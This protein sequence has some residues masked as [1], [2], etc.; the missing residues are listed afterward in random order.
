MQNIHIYTQVSPS[1]QWLHFM[2][3]HMDCVLMLQMPNCP[4]KNDQLR[5]TLDKR[6][7]SD[8]LPFIT[9]PGLVLMLP[10]QGHSC[11]PGIGI[12]LPVPEPLNSSQMLDSTILEL[13]I[14]PF[15]HLSGCSLL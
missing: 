8:R 2:H 11:F 4:P 15:H 13:R 10:G 1:A 7:V 5:A 14:F 6:S 9:H 12:S 3:N